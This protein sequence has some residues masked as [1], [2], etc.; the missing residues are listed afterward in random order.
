[1]FA[2]DATDGSGGSSSA[3]SCSSSV[4]CSG[5]RCEAMGEAGVPP[6]AGDGSSTHPL[7]ASD[8]VDAMP[9]SSRECAT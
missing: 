4:S 7:S 5:P 2:G 1:M 3:S 9:S 8:R 6:P